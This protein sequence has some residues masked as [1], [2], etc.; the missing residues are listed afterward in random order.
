MDLTEIL[1]TQIVSTSGKTLEDI[2]RE[3]LDELEKDIDLMKQENSVKEEK[4]QILIEKNEKDR[5]ILSQQ[6]LNHRERDF[7]HV[8]WVESVKDRLSQF[9]RTSAEKYETLVAKFNAYFPE[10]EIK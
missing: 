9:L 6:E 8:M 7:D 10:E 4:I 5:L 3:F 1:K 2:I